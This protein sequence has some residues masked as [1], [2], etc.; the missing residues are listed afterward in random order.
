MIIARRNRVS[1][2]TGERLDVQFRKVK[3]H[4]GGLHPFNDVCDKLAK[5]AIGIIE[6]EEISLSSVVFKDLSQY[7]NN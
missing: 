5:M 3:A 7:F 4:A 2:Y 6:R 1:N